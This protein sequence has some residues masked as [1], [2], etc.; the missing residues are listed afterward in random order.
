MKQFN[1]TDIGNAERFQ[2]YYNGR[3]LF[4]N[5]PGKWVFWTE[6]LGWQYAK[7][8]MLSKPVVQSIGN[9]ASTYEDDNRRVE[10]LKWAKASEYKS[11]QRNMLD[12]ASH[13]MGVSINQFDVKPELINCQNGVVD[14]KTRTLIPHSP[15]QLHLQRTRAHYNPN[16]R[17][18]KWAK[19]LSE[20]FEDNQVLIDWIQ[21]AAGY[22]IMG[23][24]KEH[25]FFVCHGNGRNGKDVFLETIGY[26]LGDYLHT[27]QFETFLQRDQSNVR[28]L[29]AIGALK[30]RRFA[31][32]Q[33][34]NDSTR[35]DAALI[36]RLTGGNRLVGTVI[37]K[38]RFEFDPTHTIWLACNHLPAIKDASTGMWERVKAIPFGRTFLGDEQN[39]E[40]KEELKKE[41]DGILA[42]L[43]EGAHKYL[44]REPSS[45]LPDPYV[46]KE[47]T[48][49]YRDGNDKMSIFI[50]QHMVKDGVSKTPANV[51]YNIYKDWCINNDEFPEEY[52][53]SPSKL[54]ERGVNV[55]R[56]EHGQLC[57][58]WTN[59]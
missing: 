27:A 35:L 24:T 53:F 22:S 49:E 25:H 12:L 28:V 14:L 43:V 47:A 51:F 21:V 41:A 58:G 13:Y 42:W 52:R 34:T 57:L 29:E 5:E 26:V 55:K 15:T 30:G 36:K 40:L 1:T 4:V 31:I 19:F 48:Q 37:G 46:I 33:E 20:I 2:E 18:P 8:F 16:A 23:L 6:R 7:M 59:V 17:C 39:R 54:K 9:E 45:L 3:V 11:A 44:N 10:L 32:A 50:K 56:E 38:G